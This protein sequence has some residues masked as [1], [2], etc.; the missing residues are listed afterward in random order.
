MG[1]PVSLGRHSPRGPS[2][3][4]AI[5][6]AVGLAVGLPASPLD[7]PLDGACHSPMADLRRSLPLL[8]GSGRKG[9]GREM[10]RGAPA[11]PSPGQAGRRQLCFPL[12]RPD[13]V[14]LCCPVL[15]RSAG[16]D[17]PRDEAVGRSLEGPEGPAACLPG[18]P[19][20]GALL[21]FTEL[22]ARWSRH[23]PRE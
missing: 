22:L 8:L 9:A 5:A 23:A 19:D 2:T 16:R 11:G 21:A 1:R 20:S 12:D 15:P 6:A 4:N 18:L 10:L 13:S 14:C 17:A 7:G 3:G